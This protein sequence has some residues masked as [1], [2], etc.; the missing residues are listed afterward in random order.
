MIHGPENTTRQQNVIHSGFAPMF[1]R[2]LLLFKGNTHIAVKTFIYRTCEEMT[3]VLRAGLVKFCGESRRW[4]PISDSRVWAFVCVFV[5]ASVCFFCSLW[6]WEKCSFVGNNVCT[7]CCT[8]SIVKVKS[9]WSTF[10]NRPVG[11]AWFDGY[12]IPNAIQVLVTYCKPENFR[13]ISRSSFQNASIKKK[14]KQNI[15]LSTAGHI[16]STNT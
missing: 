16:H 13:T 9:L 14:T 6:F 5:K 12:I 4:Q 11:A 7:F 8:T 2:L 1:G 10:W 3:D 15:N